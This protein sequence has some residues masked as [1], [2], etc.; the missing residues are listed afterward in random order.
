MRIKNVQ[1]PRLIGRRVRIDLRK[2]PLF[3]DSG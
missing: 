1:K 2:R 3:V